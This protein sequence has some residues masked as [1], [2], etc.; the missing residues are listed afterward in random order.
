MGEYIA[1]MG[2]KLHTVAIP[3]TQD[4]AQGDKPEDFPWKGYKQRTTAWSR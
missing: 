3:E 1:K 4:E 2:H